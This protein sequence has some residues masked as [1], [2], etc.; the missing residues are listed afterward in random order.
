MRTALNQL[1]EHHKLIGIE[2]GVFYGD[3]TLIYFKE[4]DIEKVYLIDPYTKHE[5]YLQFT[6]EILKEAEEDAHEKLKIYEDKIEWMKMRSI[7]AIDNFPN[8][9]VDFVYID[10]NHLYKFVLEDITLYY[11]KVKKDGLL[12]GHDYM[13]RIKNHVAGAVNDFCKKNNLRFNYDRERKA[14]WW[15]WK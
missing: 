15:I 6:A 4:L 12:S 11:P 1:K 10:G 14:D 7:E 5:D 3:Y 2:I 9:S 13:K 8:N